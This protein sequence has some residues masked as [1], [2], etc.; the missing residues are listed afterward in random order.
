MVYPIFWT[1]HYTV[2]PIFRT[3]YFS[4]MLYHSSAWFYIVCMEEKRKDHKSR[5]IYLLSPELIEHIKDNPCIAGYSDSRIKWSKKFL[6]EF[7]VE[8]H[9]GKS[10]AQILRDYGLDPVILGDNRISSLRGYYMRTRSLLNDSSASSERDEEQSIFTPA[11][12]TMLEH[13]VKYLSQEVDALKKIFIAD[14]QTRKAARAQRKS[15]Q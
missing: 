3:L 2:Y 14:N 7:C 4:L 10:A 15:M 11:K 12:F 9:K 5:R 6:D 8:Y 1:A 13:K